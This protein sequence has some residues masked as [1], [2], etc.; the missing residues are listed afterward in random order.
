MLTWR[1]GYAVA[2][3]FVLA[4]EIL[5]ATAVHDAFVR[6][7]VG[8]S[9]AVLL[10][11]LALR[12]VVRVGVLRAAALAFAVAAAVEFGQLI[13]LLKLLGLEANAIARTVLGSGFD[14]WDFLAYAAGALAAV[15]CD[16]YRLRHAARRRGGGGR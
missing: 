6:P 5:I 16:T 8:D 9:L 15:A 12:S 1:T 13:G 7:H 2:A 11:Y 3:A 4:V 10:V 14:P